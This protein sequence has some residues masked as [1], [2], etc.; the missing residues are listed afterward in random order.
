LVGYQNSFWLQLPE[1]FFEEASSPLE[2][3]PPWGEAT[4]EAARTKRT[5]KERLKAIRTI[6]NEGREGVRV[7]RAENVIDENVLIYA[8]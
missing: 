4:T 5:A 3:S 2:E 8:S 1:S 6:T 7:Q